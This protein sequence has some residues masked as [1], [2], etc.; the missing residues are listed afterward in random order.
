M[1][2]TGAPAKYRQA[3][4]EDLADQA[5]TF[6]GVISLE[7][8][9]HVADRRAFLDSLARLVA[10]HGILLIGT[11]NRTIRSYLTAIVGAEY[12]LKWLPRGTHD[13]R[14]FVTPAELDTDLSP[15]GIHDVECWGV[16]F[17]LLMMRWRISKD[18]STNYLRFYRKN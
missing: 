14:K 11:L 7:V 1:H 2:T 18:L 10:P 17:N 9:E 5:G 15:H 16:T 3:L 12:I 4:P 6:D 8:V 13:W